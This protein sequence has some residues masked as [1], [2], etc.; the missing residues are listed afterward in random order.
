MKGQNKNPQPAT[1]E[2]YTSNSEDTEN[3]ANVSIQIRDLWIQEAAKD[4]GYVPIKKLSTADIY[5]LSH[6]LV[7]WEN[8]DPYSG[9]EENTDTQ[10]SPSSQ[11]DTKDL[12]IPDSQ[13]AIETNSNII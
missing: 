5:N 8:I 1:S 4:L 10:E 6:G 12:S 7:D 2:H 9:L 11:S 3:L 13:Q